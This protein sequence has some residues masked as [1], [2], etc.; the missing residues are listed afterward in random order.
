VVVR[1]AQDVKAGSSQ[2]GD[3]G[4]RTI[5]LGRIRRRLHRARGIDWKLEISRGQVA[6]SH[7]R[8]E[9]SVTGAKVVASLAAMLHDVTRK[10]QA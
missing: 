7:E 8:F 6:C 1:R 2:G 10:R 9:L 3:V 5:E 4:R